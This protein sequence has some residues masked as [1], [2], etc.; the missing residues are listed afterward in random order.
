MATTALAST[1]L[2]AIV[3][4]CYFAVK[5]INIVFNQLGNYGVALMLTKYMASLK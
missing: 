4:I 3:Y 1:R 5:S 2:C